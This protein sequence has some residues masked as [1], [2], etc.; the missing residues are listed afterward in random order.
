MALRVYLICI[1][2]TIGLFQA[3][4]QNVAPQ[5]MEWKVDEMVRKALVYIPRQAKTANTPIV[6]AFHG[7]GGLVVNGRGGT[8]ENMYNTRRFDLLW[9]EAIF[10]CPQG[11]NTPGQLTDKE[12]K[13]P[14]W[15][16]AQ[17]ELND[18][19]LKFFDVM[20]ASFMKDYKVDKSR[21]YATGHSNGGGFTYLLWAA[22]GPVFAAVAPTASAGGKLL[23]MLKPKPVLHL[24]G[25]KD[26]LVKTAWQINTCNALLKMNGCVDTG[27]SFAANATLY[28]STMGNPVV[29]YR[30]PGGHSYPQAANQVIIDF[31]KQR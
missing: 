17:G 20:L 29:I 8:M 13:F 21:I 10:V 31:F 25:E 11:L 26:E 3:Q 27:E 30:H 6:F 24:Y 12:G 15:Q 2:L 7:H 9:P 5:V 1:G 28:K 19:D 16:K 22:R 14:G 4:G 18:R 23:S